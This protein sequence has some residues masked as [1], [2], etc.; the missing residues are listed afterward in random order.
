MTLEQ[1]AVIREKQT[2]RN[3]EQDQAQMEGTF[4]FVIGSAK[5]SG[6]LGKLLRCV[7][8]AVLECLYS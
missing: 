3:L 7:N 2:G 1:G 5:D 6:Q 8:Q 4:M